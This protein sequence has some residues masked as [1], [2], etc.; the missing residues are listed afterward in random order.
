VLCADFFRRGGLAYGSPALTVFVGPAAGSPGAARARALVAQLD[1]SL[2]MNGAFSCGKLD[3]LSP[4]GLEWAPLLD[5]GRWAS[6]PRWAQPHPFCDLPPN[7][8]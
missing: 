6:A 8:R 7:H 4:R 5:Y 2:E 3:P 1:P